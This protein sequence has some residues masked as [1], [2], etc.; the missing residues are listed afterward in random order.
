[1]AENNKFKQTVSKHFDN[2]AMQSNDELLGEF[3]SSVNDK[4]LRSPYLYVENFLE[5][6]SFNSILDYCCGTGIYSIFPAK[7][8]AKVHGIDISEKSIN[9]AKIR[10]SFFK[11]NDLCTFEVADAESIPSADASFELVLSYGSFSYLDMN[12][13]FKD[14]HRVLCDDG[15]LIIVDSLGHNPLF[16]M[17]R[18]RNIMNYAPEYYKQLK[19]LQVNDVKN[20]SRDYFTV[21]EIKYFDLFSVLGSYLS[22]FLDLNI[23]PNIFIK[24]D[25]LLSKTPFIGKYFF[26]AV[27]ILKKIKH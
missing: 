21:K 6:H 15:I 4:F 14:I 2:Q 17:N 18:K 16:N 26:K 19:T 1:M 10:A 23:N 20:S 7:K 22:R 11:V 9:T 27:F 24:A 12:K 25:F 3:G 13:A 8:G 5:A